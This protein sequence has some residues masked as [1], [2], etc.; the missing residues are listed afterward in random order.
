MYPVILLSGC[1]D[2]LTVRMPF[3]QL[4]FLALKLVLYTHCLLKHM[5]TKDREKN[6]EREESS[7][8]N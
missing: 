1:L 4:Y 6:R 5:N 2:F 3:L 7:E 8:E